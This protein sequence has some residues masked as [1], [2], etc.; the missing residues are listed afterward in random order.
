MY[1][2][3]R[4]L[5]LFFNE[6]LALY[7]GNFNINKAPV[8]LKDALDKYDIHRC[9]TK[10][11]FNKQNASPIPSMTANT[12]ASSISASYNPPCVPPTTAP[13]QPSNP[14]MQQTDSRNQRVVPVYT[15]PPTNS[16]VQQQHR[17]TYPQHQHGT[18]S[19]PKVG[20]KVLSVPPSDIVRP[21]TSYGRRPALGSNNATKQSKNM[22][23]QLPITHGGD[24]G[25]NNNMQSNSNNKR[26]PLGA[27][28]H[29][30]TTSGISSDLSSK[31]QK[32]QRH[33]NPYN[34]SVTGRKS[35]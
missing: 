19:A 15:N 4:L 1:S 29:Y 23:S 32:Q 25:S 33:H 30:P 17:Q 7:S 21:T 16:S 2:H 10:F 24:G 14:K 34:H 8:S 27:I 13:A 9:N 12:T 26:P 20:S 18:T 5:F 35:I 6:T 31:R 3:V 28:A 22:I 11:G